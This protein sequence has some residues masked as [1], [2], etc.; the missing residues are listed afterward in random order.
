MKICAV[1][2]EYNPLHTGH[3]YQLDLLKPDFDAVVVIM[4][5]N[6]TQRGDVAII[7]KWERAKTAILSGA[8]LVIELPTVFAMNTAER[9]AFGAIS[10]MNDLNCINS[11]SF[12]S[13][14][15]DIDKLFSAAKLLAEEPANIKEKIS[16]Y[17]S[18]GDAFAVARTKAFSGLID[19]S[20]LSMPNNILALEYMRQL[21]LTGST[22]KPVTHQRLGSGY[23][24]T[25]IFGSFSSASA[26]RYSYDNFKDIKPYMPPDCFDIYKNADKYLLDMLNNA[27]VY[28]IRTGGPECLKNHLECTEGI[29]NRIYRAAKSA[30]SFTDIE[31]AA[32]SKRTTR[33]KIR[34]IILG[35]MLGIDKSLSSKK[36]EYARVLAAS[37]T[38]LDILAGM[39]DTSHI[40]TITKAAAYK[41]KDIMFEK[42]ILAGDIFALANTNPKKRSAGEDYITSPFILKTK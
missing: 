17:V 14:C 9:F 15:G 39:K 8:D 20:L 22:I 1:T 3:K 30:S 25:T 7:N 36:P 12:G 38:G 5:G 10:I 28:F 13:E 32:S 37:S 42:D 34:R 40:K 29:E 2:A 27:A 19:E 21:I 26:L 41:E 4:S 23:N 6:F 33:A 35:S 24:S 11:V 31:N 16:Q 18:D